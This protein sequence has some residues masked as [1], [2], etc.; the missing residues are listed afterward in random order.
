MMHNLKS[1]NWFRNGAYAVYFS[2]KNTGHITREVRKLGN[3]VH[4]KSLSWFEFL[5]HQLVDVLS[6]S[7][8]AQLEY[9][10]SE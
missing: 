6:E 8:I 2:V 9:E 1:R 4:S 7:A 10:I 3:F 5:V